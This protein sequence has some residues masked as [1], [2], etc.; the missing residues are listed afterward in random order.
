M[1]LADRCVNDRKSDIYHIY[2][3]QNERERKRERDHKL[4]K[5]V[6][7]ANTNSGIN[8]TSN[9]WLQTAHVP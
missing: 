3:R 8:I 6:N 1:S 7:W 5:Q 9:E 2:S 4:P